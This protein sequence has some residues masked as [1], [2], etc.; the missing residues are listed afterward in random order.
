MRL[1]IS[2]RECA[3]PR[4]TKDLPLVYRQVFTQFLNIRHKIPSRIL[5]E[6]RMRRALPRSALIEQHNAIS[7]RIV[8]L[9]I[10]RHESTTRP[11]MQ[12][13]HRL[14]V[15]IATLLVIDLVNVRHF[16]TAG[17]VGFDWIVKGSEFWHEHILLALS[18]SLPNR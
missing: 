8:K 1:S 14:A 12:K 6:R 7:I 17:V 3:A 13:H 11:T 10:L 5:F 18:A 9:P 4:P 2:Q 16:Q 15:W